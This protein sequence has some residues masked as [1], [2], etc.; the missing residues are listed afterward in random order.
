MASRGFMD[1]EKS[2]SI[3]SNNDVAVATDRG[4]WSTLANPEA[5]P[6]QPQ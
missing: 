1:I 6:E 4:E 3:V 5:P 2:P